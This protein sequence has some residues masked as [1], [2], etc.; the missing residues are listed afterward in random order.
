MKLRQNASQ[1]PIH[2][3]NGKPMRRFLD[4]V[5]LHAESYLVRRDEESGRVVKVIA[6][7]NSLRVNGEPARQVGKNE[8]VIEF[9]RNG[10]TDRYSGRKMAD[11]EL[12]KHIIDEAN[13]LLEG[14]METFFQALAR[15]D[16]ATNGTDR[17]KTSRFI[18]PRKHEATAPVEMS[19]I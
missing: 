14:S 17:N 3:I 15:H 12:A 6:K 16:V 5:P 2:Q 1:Y 9:L 18:H 11:L 13:G 10:E 19:G 8:F 7:L 4:L